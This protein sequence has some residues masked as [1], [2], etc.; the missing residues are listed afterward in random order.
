MKRVLITGMSGTGMS[1]VAAALAAHG[2]K[3]IGA[4]THGLSELV[5]SLK[6]SPPAWVPARTARSQAPAGVRAIRTY[7][8]YSSSI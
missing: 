4:D 7:V 3:A 8:P 1:T 2:H 6:P 5:R